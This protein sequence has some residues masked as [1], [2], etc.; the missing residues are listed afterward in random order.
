MLNKKWSFYKSVCIIDIAGILIF[1]LVSAYNVFIT[2]R[3]VLGKEEKAGFV[4]MSICLSIILGSD[5]LG[6]RL[7]SKF[8]KSNTIKKTFQNWLILFYIAVCIFFILLAYFDYI[9]IGELMELHRSYFST[10]IDWWTIA[11]FIELLLLSLTSLYKII[12]TWKLVKDVK[13]NHVDFYTSIDTIGT[14]E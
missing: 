11:L 3:A 8:Q 7:T 12:F 13:K 5:F 14:T 4:I 2:N 1:I 9:E 6:I 10:P